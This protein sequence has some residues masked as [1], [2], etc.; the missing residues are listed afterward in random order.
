MEQVDRTESERPSE[1]AAGSAPSDDSRADTR[2]AD[3][4][5]KTTESV[6]GGQ[7][8]VGIDIFVHSHLKLGPEVDYHLIQNFS[9][10][11]RSRKNF[12]GFSFSFEFGYV[13]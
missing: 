4:A 13:F 8:Q 11:V 2:H 7:A 12:S 6:L 5:G 10:K 1:S 9:D 3:Q